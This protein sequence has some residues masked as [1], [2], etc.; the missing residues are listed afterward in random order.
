LPPGQHAG[1]REGGE[2][3]PRRET[4]GR[5]SRSHIGYRCQPMCPPHDRCRTTTGL[6]RRS[7]CWD[8]GTSI[9]KDQ[10]LNIGRRGQ[11]AGLSRKAATEPTG[12]G[13]CTASRSS[14]GTTGARGKTLD[15][16]APCGG[17]TAWTLTL[18]GQP[19]RSNRRASWYFADSFGQGQLSELAAATLND[20]T[21]PGG[22]ET[23]VGSAAVTGV[24]T[25]ADREGTTSPRLRWDI[26]TAAEV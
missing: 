19:R 12:A 25:D 8:D 23:D 14:P 22:G 26:A 3:G 4:L 15:V 24:N 6:A 7:R 20:V 18:D 10:T 13:H 1:H 21:S 17:E 16:R 2:T 5:V 11:H 9:K